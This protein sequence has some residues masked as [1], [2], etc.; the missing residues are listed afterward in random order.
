MEW[1]HAGLGGGL[2][3]PATCWFQA[4]P[5]LGVAEHETSLAVI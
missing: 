4:V 2:R 3:V 5:A 1:F